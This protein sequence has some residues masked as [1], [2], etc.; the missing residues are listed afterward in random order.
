MNYKNKAYSTTTKSKQGKDFEAFYYQ[1]NKEQAQ[2]NLIN[3]WLKKTGK[4]L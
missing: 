2:T 4:K 3:A 1:K